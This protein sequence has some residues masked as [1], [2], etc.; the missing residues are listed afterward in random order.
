MNLFLNNIS[1]HL[2][3]HK[4]FVV[5]FFIVFFMVGFIGIITPVWHQLF[6]KLFPL[7]LLL[8]FFALLIFH[9]P[10]YN[11]KTVIVLLIIGL[12][13]FF[14]EVAGVNTH[15]I[16]GNYTYGKSLGMQFFN[17]PLLIGINWV[18]LTFACSSMIEKQVLPVSLKIIIA[19]FLMLLYDIILE[20]LAPLLDMW[21][22]AK[23][24]VPFQNYIAWFVLAVL[25]QSLVK[26]TGIKTRNSLA[27][28]IIFCQ[29][30]FFISLIIYFSYIA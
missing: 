18:M 6:M 28:P 15:L 13:G 21:Y 9:Q 30:L 2:N 26:I 24:I 8:S 11:T 25:F 29:A 4:K 1:D 20:Q 23:G 5:I 12:S 16:F 14:I 7:A 17:T 27:I 10:S 22:W 3:H 19:S